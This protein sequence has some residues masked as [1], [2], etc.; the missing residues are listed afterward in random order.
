M[1]DKR[2][3]FIGTD[4]RLSAC[5]RLMAERG[6]TCHHAETNA[7]TKRLGEVITD[8]SPNHIVFPILQMERTLPSELLRNGTRLYTGVASEDWLR[9]YK[10]HDFRIESYLQEEQFI[11]QN[12]RLTAEAFI[13]EFYS[14]RKQSVAEKKFYVAGFGKVGKMVAHVLSAL[15]A[16]VTI[17]ARSAK[18]LAE[19][20]ALRYSTRLLTSDIVLQESCLVNTIPAQWLSAVGNEKFHIFDLASAPG[21]LKVARADEYYTILPG[22]PGIHFPMDAAAALADVLDRMYRR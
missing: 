1:N 18:Q 19:A 17:I 7:Y 16:E 2:W 5:S 4:K 15:G 13:A 10:E 20:G 6:H 14:L 11:W 12:A 3:L 22:L 8:F 21:C 9:S